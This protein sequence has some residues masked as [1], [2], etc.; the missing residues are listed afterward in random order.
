MKTKICTKPKCLKEKLLSE[1]SKDKNTKDGLMPIC[2]ECIK[3]YHEENKERLNK[4]RRD[5]Y[6]KYPW[7]HTL[8][9]IKD[10]CNNKNFKDYIR[11]GGRGIECNITS[12]E[13]EFL[14]FR[15][16]AYDMENP[17]IDREN[18]DGNYELSNCRYIEKSEN[19]AKDKRKPVLQYDLNGNFIKE[20]NSITHASKILN[21]TTGDICK[22][23][24]GK[25]N[26]AG[27]FIWKYKNG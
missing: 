23:A 18:N 26:H 5:F 21:I 4:N 25:G 7:K 24:Q 17:S 1:F 27:G 22:I 9:S 14:W 16:K 19:S 12:D 6:K 3:K 10:R 20:W 2:K 11:Y 8:K 15:D 13:L